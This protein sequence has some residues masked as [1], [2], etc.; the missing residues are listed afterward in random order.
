M[1]TN[2]DQDFRALL[3]V[4]GTLVIHGS[5]EGQLSGANREFSKKPALF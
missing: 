3:I 5:F 2:N 1:N 4:F